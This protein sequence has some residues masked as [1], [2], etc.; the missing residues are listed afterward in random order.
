MVSGI[1]RSY[2]VASTAISAP[3]LNT[4]NIRDNRLVTDANSNFIS[5]EKFSQIHKGRVLRNDI[6]MTT[7]GPTLELLR[8]STAQYITALVNAQMLILRPHSDQVDPRFFFY[9]LTGPETQQHLLDYRTGSAQ[10]QLP[11]RDLK[12]IPIRVPRSLDK[13]KSHR[14]GAWRW[15]TRSS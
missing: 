4:T 5:E 10:P 8:C 1:S 6:V 11:I 15:T 7:R 2:F 14:G 9:A 13:T 3:L 12:R